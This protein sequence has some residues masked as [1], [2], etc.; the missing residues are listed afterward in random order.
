MQ[1]AKR[2]GEIFVERDV[3]LI[4]GGGKIGLMGI[5]SDTV[6]KGGGEVIGVIPSFLEKLEVGNSEVSELIITDNMHSRK[7]T[8]FEKSDGFVIMPGGIGTLEE[9]FEVATWKQLKVHS[10]PIVAMN[11]G[12]YWSGLAE[13]IDAIVSGGFANPEVRDLIDFV[14]TPEDVFN[15]LET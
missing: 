7:Q 15:V 11:I 12:G 2:L 3:R 5:I 8:M 10:K 6:L 1:A 9:A 14:E 13:I 4:Y